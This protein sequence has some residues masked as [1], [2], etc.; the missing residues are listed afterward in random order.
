VLSAIGLFLSEH[1]YGDPIMWTGLLIMIVS[2]FAGVLTV[3]S[4]LIKEK[5]WKWVKVATLLIVIMFIGL[6]FSMLRN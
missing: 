5:D 3:Y 1:E 4:N 2:P 6:I